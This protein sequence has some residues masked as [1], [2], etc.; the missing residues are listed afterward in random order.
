MKCGCLKIGWVKVCSCV[1]GYRKL[2]PYRKPGSVVIY[3]RSDFAARWLLPRIGLLKKA[4]PHCDP[5]IDTSGA[6]VDFEEMEVSIAIVCARD[7]D[8][9]LQSH[10][11]FSDELVA[12]ASPQILK[13]NVFSPHD[14]LDFPLIHDERPVGWEEWYESGGVTVGEVSAG[15]DFSDSELALQAAETGYGI[16]LASKSLVVDDS[17]EPRGLIIAS[18]HT[19]RTSEI[20]FALST[21]KELSDPFTAQTWNWLIAASGS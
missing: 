5:W 20:W 3:C 18:D 1:K 6:K 11:L 15:L 2:E 7:V 12:V 8:P 13:E 19:L 17:V 16:A 14:L 9:S 4:V 21:T 10:L